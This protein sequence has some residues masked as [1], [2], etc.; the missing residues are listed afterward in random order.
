MEPIETAP[1]KTV[2]ILHMD[3]KHSLPFVCVGMRKPYCRSV[4]FK[5]VWPNKIDDVPE[6]FRVLGW[7]PLPGNV[8]PNKGRT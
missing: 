1:K 8:I 6:G 4:K 7:E 3:T 2:I 5:R